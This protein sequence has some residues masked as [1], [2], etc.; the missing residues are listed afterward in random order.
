MCQSK[1]V[2]FQ[3]IPL[4]IYPTAFKTVLH[5]LTPYPLHLA[6]EAFLKNYQFAGFVFLSEK[7]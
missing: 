2:K 5:N 1:P 4:C 7:K 3:A 6:I